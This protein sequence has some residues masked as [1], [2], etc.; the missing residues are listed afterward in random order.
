MK[1]DF[2]ISHRDKYPFDSRY[3]WDKSYMF[4]FFDNEGN[5]RGNYVARKLFYTSKEIKY[6]YRGVVI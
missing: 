2:Y 3:W 6:S 4:Y 1:L 5:P